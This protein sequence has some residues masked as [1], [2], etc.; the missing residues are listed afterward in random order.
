MEVENNVA[1]ERNI[2][3]RAEKGQLAKSGWQHVMNTY[4]IYI[5]SNKHA[6]NTTTYR[7]CYWCK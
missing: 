3:M 2:L 4:T 6:Q 1:N 7:T 5:N